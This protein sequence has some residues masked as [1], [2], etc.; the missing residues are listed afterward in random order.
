MV[1]AVQIEKAFTKQEIL[2]FYCN[3][4][5]MGHGRYGIEAAAE[6]YFGKPA[7]ELR[8]EESALLAGLVQRPEAYSPVRSPQRAQ[9]R[10]NHVLDRM[11][12]EGELA[13]QEGDPGDRRPV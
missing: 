13:R 3:Q 8:L 1:L 5:Y 10:R 9:S 11:V 6:F 7:K 4:V 12:R 2:G